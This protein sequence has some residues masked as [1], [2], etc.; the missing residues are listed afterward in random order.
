MQEKLPRFEM[1]CRHS[2]AAGIPPASKGAGGIGSHP[3]TRSATASMDFARIGPDRSPN[4]KA[5]TDFSRGLSESNNLFE[6]LSRNQHPIRRIILPSERSGIRS[7]S[8]LCVARNRGRFNGLARRFRN[9]DRTFARAL[10]HALR[11]SGAT[12]SAAAAGVTA[13]V[14]TG[15]AATGRNVV[16]PLTSTA[17]QAARAATLVAAVVRGRT[18]TRVAAGIAAIVHRSGRRTTAR[19]GGVAAIDLRSAAVVLRRAA[20]V[21][22]ATAT[23]TAGGPTTTE[24]GATAIVIA[25]LRENVRRRNCYEHRGRHGQTKFN[26]PTH[27]KSPLTKNFEHQSCTLEPPQWIMPV[28][29]G[30]EMAIWCISGE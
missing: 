12:R 21:G 3:R 22:V 5:A 16:A 8:N 27:R 2:A 26:H 9:H 23:R 1:A 11:A 7:E 19:R 28:R 14:T 18:T 4:G 10:D 6:D 13:G 24:T 25:A 30:D 29:D 17:K 15:V 20:G